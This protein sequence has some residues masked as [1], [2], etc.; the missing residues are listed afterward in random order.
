M[1]VNTLQLIK[2]SCSSRPPSY[3]ATFRGFTASTVDKDKCTGMCLYHL[4]VYSTVL[5]HLNVAN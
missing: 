4:T 1:L 3:S 5:Y 2:A